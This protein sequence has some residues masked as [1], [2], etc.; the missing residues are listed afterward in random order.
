M[1]FVLLLIFQIL[2]KGELV[3]LETVLEMIKD[4]MFA[5]QS[6]TGFLIDGYPRELDQGKKFEETVRVFYI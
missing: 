1:V 4:K 5:N 3:P 2:V 6:A